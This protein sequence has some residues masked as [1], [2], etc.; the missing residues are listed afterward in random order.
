MQSLIN[1]K[2]KFRESFRPFAPTVLL[3]DVSDYFELDR[4]S[5][6]MLLV[7]PVNRDRLCTPTPELEAITGLDKRNVVRSE[8]PAVTHVDNSARIQTVRRDDNPLYY[9]M[10]RAF[11]QRTGCPLVINTSFNVRGEPIV[12]TPHDAYTCFMRTHMDYLIMGSFL[13]DKKDQ[14]PW[15]EDVDWMRDY[16]LD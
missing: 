5:P 6:Y 4:E 1:L 14:H 16:V 3:D 8:V 11:A 13:L 10:I 7:A 12:C 2:I 15:T 9:D